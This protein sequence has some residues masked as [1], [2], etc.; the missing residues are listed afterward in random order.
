MSWG[1]WKNK[2]GY[3]HP[4]R[5]NDHTQKT[6]DETQSCRPWYDQRRSQV[7]DE[8]WGRD[9]EIHD[10]WEL[11]CYRQMSALSRTKGAWATAP[12][13]T[14][15]ALLHM[16]GEPRRVLH[17]S[18]SHNLEVV[19]MKILSQFLKLIVL[20][21]ILPSKNINDFLL[22]GGFFLQAH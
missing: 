18:S 10:S 22:I 20:S 3:E 17:K 21:L 11:E 15:F 14:V 13:R 1:I 19:H 4:A 5:S 8:K 2:E 16:A 12:R 7:C 6:Y 9:H